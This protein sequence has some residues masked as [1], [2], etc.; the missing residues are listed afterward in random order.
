M[1][2]TATFSNGKTISRNSKRNYTHAYMVV[3]ANP[4]GTTYVSDIGFASSKDLATKASKANSNY[5]VKSEIV[6]VTLGE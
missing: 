5:V 4:N 1:K 3:S 2:V 6:E